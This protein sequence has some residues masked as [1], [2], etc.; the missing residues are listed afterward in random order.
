[1][2][3]CGLLNWDDGLSRLGV[4]RLVGVMD[5]HASPWH[6]ELGLWTPMSQYGPLSCRFSYSFLSKLSGSPPPPPLSKQVL[7]QGIKILK[8][9]PPLPKAHGTAAMGVL[10]LSLTILKGLKT[11]NQSNWNACENHNKEYEDS[12]QHN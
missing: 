4:A 6:L 1:M 5:S 9:G 12:L 11:G 7:L 2:L 8:N 10:W 3:R